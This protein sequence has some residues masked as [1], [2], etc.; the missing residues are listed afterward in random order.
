MTMAAET[1][2]D[3][4]AAEMMT[5]AAAHGGDTGEDTGEDTG[6]EDAE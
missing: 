3:D 5:V 4:K 1:T 6:G 2:G